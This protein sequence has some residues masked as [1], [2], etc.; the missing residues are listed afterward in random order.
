MQ[1]RAFAPER[2]ITD[3]RTSPFRPPLE[4]HIRAVAVFEFWWKQLDYVFDL[5]DPRAFPPLPAAVASAQH[6][7]VDRYVRI[8]GDLAASS[9]LNTVDEGFFVRMPD[10]PNGPGGD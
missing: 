8:A 6:K 3:W 4:E 5:A 9:L 10:G 2:L 1:V 7:V